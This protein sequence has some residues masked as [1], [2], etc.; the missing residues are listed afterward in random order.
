MDT[1]ER[2]AAYIAEQVK[3]I[4][5][6]HGLTQEN[7]AD[8]A[9]LTTRTIEKV[10]SGRHR[11]EE[12]TLR[13]IARAVQIDVKFFVKP[14]PEEQARQKAEMERAVRKMVVAPTNAIRSASDFLGAFAARHAFRIDTSNV[15]T[16][17][18]L[19][20]AAA[21]TDF[22]TDLNDVWDDCPRSQQLEYAR[23]FVELC[24]QM[25]KLGFVCHMGHHRQRLRQRDQPAH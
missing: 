1:M 2:D 24:R 20:T 25:E 18:A 11:P 13:S 22:I 19:E 21:M 7:L 16:D 14:T 4:R 17:D 8:A 10:E 15:A 5:K 12:Q 23:S 3:F 6:W 9:G